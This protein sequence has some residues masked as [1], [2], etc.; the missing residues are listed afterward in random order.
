MK[1]HETY[2]VRM[3]AHSIILSGQGY[4]IDKIADI[5]QVHRNSVTGWIEEWE[6]SG[7]A[8]LFDKPKSG[9]PAILDEAEQEL[10]KQI[11]AQ[12]PRSTKKA[13]S[14][15]EKQT[16]KEISPDTLKRIIKGADYMWK[17]V[18]NFKI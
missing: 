10:A 7:Y 13:I 18:K 2:R 16:G 11:V 17:R 3:R 5:Y 8:S 9:R 14:E 6:E 1:M 15:I 4:S 12:T